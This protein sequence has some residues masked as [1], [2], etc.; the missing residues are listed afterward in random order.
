MKLTN[1]VPAFTMFTATRYMLVNEFRGR[2]YWAVFRASKST[3]QVFYGEPIG[4]G[5]A[6]NLPT[7]ICSAKR[8]Q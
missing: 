4:M 2:F 6:Y 1:R 8:C 3:N 7:A 5:S